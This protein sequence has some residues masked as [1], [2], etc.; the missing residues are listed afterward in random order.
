MIFPS[1]P[2]TMF[3]GS[4]AREEQETKDVRSPCLPRLKRV[5]CG[6]SKSL[7]ANLSSACFCRISVGRA[8]PLHHSSRTVGPRR[9]LS[10]RTAADEGVKVA[11]VI[12]HVGHGV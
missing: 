8:Q 4:A 1:C 11:F 12:P 2:R 6:R 7:Q 9:E 5:P 3:I 10:G